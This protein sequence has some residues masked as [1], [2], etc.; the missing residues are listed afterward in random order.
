M[1]LQSML[2]RRCPGVMATQSNYTPGGVYGRTRRGLGCLLYLCIL[3][4]IIIL[5]VYI[6]TIPGAWKCTLTKMYDQISV[7]YI[8]TTPSTHV[9][10]GYLDVV[11][12]DLFDG[13]LARKCINLPHVTIVSCVCIGTTAST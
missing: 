1:L 4:Y 6:A 7:C 13:C 5:C 12:L 9:D 11:S 2:A 10:R 8:A 3:L